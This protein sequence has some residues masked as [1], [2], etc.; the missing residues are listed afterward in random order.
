M[1]FCRKCECKVEDCEHLVWPIEC[2]RIRVFDEKVEW[3]A[4]AEDKRILEIAFKSGQVWQLAGVPA[5]I[6]AELRNSTISSFLKFIAAR[7]QASA[8]KTGVY[9][10]AVPKEERCPVCESVMNEQNRTPGALNKFI[11]VFWLCPSCKKSKWESYG[12][13]PGRERRARWH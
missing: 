4:Y 12:S 9:A 8:V 6:Y 2:K 1:V 11:R 5:G 10:I 3:V 13:Q 7:Y